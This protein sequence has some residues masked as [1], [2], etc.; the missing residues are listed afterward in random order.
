LVEGK[1]SNHNFFF[2]LE[3][4][5]KKDNQS[6][7]NSSSVVKKIQKPF[8]IKHYLAIAL[9]PISHLIRRSSLTFFNIGGMG[10]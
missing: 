1:N 9:R 8:L 6:V 3:M 4:L 7:N 5:C 2:P 10:M